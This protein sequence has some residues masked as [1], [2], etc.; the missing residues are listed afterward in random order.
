MHEH[1]LDFPFQDNTLFRGLEIDRE[2]LTEPRAL[3]K[4]YL[5]SKD[6]FVAQVRNR[7]ATLGIDYVLMSTAEPIDAALSSY[8]AFRQ[9]KSQSVRRR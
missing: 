4:A 6:R 2:L 7:C 3:R 8:L 1:E 9:Q 5:E